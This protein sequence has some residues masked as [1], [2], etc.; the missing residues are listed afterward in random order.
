MN[1]DTDYYD[2]NDLISG[3]KAHWCK[4]IVVILGK[5]FTGKTRLWNRLSATQDGV[6]SL[7]FKGYDVSLLPGLIHSECQ[8]WDDMFAWICSKGIYKYLIIDDADCG[9]NTEGFWDALMS[10]NKESITLKV[11][12]IA[13]ID[14]A[15]TELE[16]TTF[17]LAL[18]SWKELSDHLDLTGKELKELLC[19][20]GG[21]PEIMTEFTLHGSFEEKLAGV[22]TPGSAFWNLAPKIL[23]RH[24]SSVETYNT[25]LYSMTQGNKALTTIAKASGMKNNACLE[26]LKKLLAKGLIR[27]K[28]SQNGH[29]EYFIVNSY[30]YLWFAFVY[31]AR[32]NAAF[33][34]SD[35]TVI[36]F[37]EKLRKEV[38]RRFLRAA[39]LEYLH[40]FY[41]KR[42]NFDIIK[43]E[44]HQDVTI[45]KV[46]FDYVGED[47][48]LHRT[49][50]FKCGII[51][52][53]LVKKALRA[54][55]QT[56]FPDKEY[57]FL[58]TNKSIPRECWTIAKTYDNV[59]IVQEKSLYRLY[60][61]PCE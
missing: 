28:E 42:W 31:T 3:I 8:T 53:R 6:F 56:P 32:F 55:K 7:S 38:Y 19:I 45:D 41:Y 10:L 50:L 49:V 11:V 47:K 29:K 4:D 51:K 44:L 24:F 23:E 54:M 34:M 15:P 61:V 13:S 35:Q 60:G 25:I 37:D 36:D 58:F 14:T 57:V 48:Y 30:I 39:S 21:Y 26:Y 59:H 18:M 20:T 2:Y 9:K 5:P 43:D 46:N 22:L 16:R 17:E 52:T 40:D 1:K 33:A 27:Q 12:L